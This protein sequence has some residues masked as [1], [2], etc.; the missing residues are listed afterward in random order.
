LAVASGGR[1]DLGICLILVLITAAVYAQ[2][3][4][5]GFVNL[6]DPTY[7]SQNRHVQAGLTTGSLVWALTSTEDANWFPVT[8]TSLLVDRQLY[9]RQAGGYHVTNVVLHILGALFLFGFLKRA[10]GAR[11]PSAVAAFL[12]A[13]HPLHVE[14]VVWISERKDVLSALFWFLTLCVYLYY[15]ERPTRSRYALLLLTFSVGLMSKSMLVTLP[16][17]LLLLDFWPC[18]RIQRSDTRR[19]RGS[20]ILEKVPL[21]ALS[22][23]VSVLTYVAQRDAG[24]VAPLNLYPLGWRLEN[25]LVSYLVYVWKMFW[26]SG[27]AVQYPY[28]ALPMWQVVVAALFL[29]LTTYFTVRAWRSHP[30]LAV[31][32]FWYVG[33][34]LPVIGLVQLGSQSRADRY[35]YLPMVGLSIMIGWGGADI[36]KRWPRFKPAVTGLA[37]AACAALVVVTWFQVGYWSDS[38]N[39]L[40]RALAVTENNSTAHINLATFYLN[41]KRYDDALIHGQE[42]VRLQPDSVEAQV[43]LA[44]ALGNLGQTADSEKHFRAALHLQPGSA[45]AHSWLGVSLFYQGKAEEA[46]QEELTALRIDPDYPA[47][48]DNLG[49]LLAASNRRQEAISQFAEAVRLD[50]DNAGFHRNFGTAL[51]SLEQFADAIREFREAVQLNPSDLQAHFN[52]GSALAMNGSLDDAITEFSTVVRGDAGF[53]GARQSLQ[54]ALALKNGEK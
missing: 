30:Y 46:L 39:L 17:V 19:A 45:K 3:R 2:V 50:P 41:E 27:L 14:S 13:L 51:A 40:N 18:H 29:G 47:G 36:L 8:R 37:T 28:A 26:P 10:T 38:E 31:G 4:L 53:P 25:A 1:L 20:L 42:A 44:A 16:F 12:F 11:W 54:N 6:D 24:A 32:W 33:T 48:H 22:I 9:G 35:T 43:N 52:L 34:L 23:A 7:V 49:M 5:F 15:V 21:V